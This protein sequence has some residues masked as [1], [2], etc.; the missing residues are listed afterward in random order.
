MKTMKRSLV[1]CAGVT[2]L[3][4]NAAHAQVASPATEKFFVNVNFGGQ[5]SSRT[6]ETATTKTIYD[7]PATLAS[8][9]EI[10]KGGLFDV[11]VGYRITGD[12]YVG[13][14]ISRFA[15]S[16]DATY[17][18]SIPDPVVFGRPKTST[19]TEPDLSRTEVSFN[20][21]VTWV[22]PLTDK[23]DISVGVG[24]AIIQLTQEL[25]SDFS[26]PVGTQDVIPIIREEKG[27]ATGFYGSAD[28]I[29]NLAARYGVGGFVRYSGGKADLDSAPD[30]SVGGIQVGGGIRLRF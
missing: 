21:N 23:L 8:A 26:V 28:V 11:G 18:A 29:Y 30:Q 24:V 3:V 10:G 6:L 16:G 1:L 17:T 19:G 27:T 22:M 25:A 5:L 7:E 12:I 15:D 4:A 2:L 9:L 13:L 20:P 14:A